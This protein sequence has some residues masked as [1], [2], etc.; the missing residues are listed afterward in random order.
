MSGMSD[1]HKE[2]Y[3]EE[4][5]ELLGELE[6]ALLE[7]EDNPENEELIGRVFRAMHTIKGS[8]AM[9]GF[10]DIADF[11]HEVETMF[12]LVRNG[13]AP[14]TKELIDLTLAS[15]DYIREMLEASSGGTPADVE[16]G[17][18]IIADMKH[19]VP[20]GEEKAEEAATEV[21][22]EALTS[23]DGVTYRIIFK[24]PQDIFMM[25]TNPLFMLE[26]LRSLGKCRV[27]AQMCNIPR[28]EE[29][30]P[31]NCYTY[32]DIILTTS[33]GVDAIRD[34]FIFLEDESHIM[35]DVIDESGALDEDEDYKMLGEILLERR[36][37]TATELKFAL[38]D[39]ARLGESLVDSGVLNERQVEAALL[40]QVHVKEVRQQRKATQDASTIRVTSGKLDTLVDL[41][42]ELVTVQAHLTQVAGQKV[43]PELLSISEEVERLTAELH[44][45]TMSIRMVPIGSTFSKFRR[46][47]RDLS[48][49]LKRQ[50]SLTTK[51]AETELDKTVIERL[52]DPMVHLIRNSIDHGI[53]QPEV[54]E[55][56]GKP[57]Q[58]T[59]HLEARHSGANVLI[60][61]RDDGKGLDAKAIRA[62][63][64]ER[65][66]IAPD[67]ELPEKEIF[68]L[69]ALPGFSMA[70]KVT[71]VSGRG[72]GM[73]V[74]KRN[75]E[76][77]RGSLDIS[78]KKG[79]GT[80]ITLRIPLTLAI[81]EGLLVKLGEGYFVFP[82]L[83]VEEC[84]ELTQ[85]DV[86]NAHGRD[87]INV[88]GSI[89][90]YINLRKHFNI[91]GSRPDIEQVVLINN[92]GQRIGF[93]VDHVIGEH[94]TVIK[95]LGT[96]YKDVQ[97]IS[98]ATILGDGTVALIVD[99]PRL[100]EGVALVE[101]T[102]LEGRH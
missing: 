29:M 54:R 66:M 98:G 60:Q 18:K 101:Q 80:T 90:P 46:L 53:E 20:L 51:G 32:W 89:V 88:R 4:A 34:V 71:G 78:S 67:A 43:D 28:L 56:A 41:V 68:N 93:V 36:D 12:D 42:G 26:D 95:T 82:L 75:I 23:K 81:I 40:E 2:T 92:E 47:V 17:E 45:N 84:V 64:V 50:V 5:Y 58:G 3:R 70:G 24:P 48:A 11:T 6:E 13:M 86:Q 79:V 33:A 19:T 62:K 72:V 39:K 35:I 55:L 49:E 7:L 100:I 65:G 15:R 27:V 21:E 73:D 25:G 1:K 102:A 57:S 14:V 99:V 59:V 94:Q 30:D 97:G 16:R 9:F 69:V 37:I 85:K 91:N 83:S 8:G 87:I 31:E 38:S 77:L 96:A 76:A 22:E 52:N 61:I 44:D 10:D 74:V 63:A